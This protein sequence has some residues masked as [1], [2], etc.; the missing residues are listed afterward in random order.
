M[1]KKAM[2]TIPAMLSWTGIFIRKSS[3]LSIQ[4]TEIHF[5]WGMRTKRCRY[6][7]SWLTPFW[8]ILLHGYCHLS[9]RLERCSADW[10]LTLVSHW[11]RVITWPGYWPLIGALQCWLAS[12]MGT[13][14][15]DHYSGLNYPSLHSG[16]PGW[17]TVLA[18]LRRS[19]LGRFRLV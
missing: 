3:K 1:A 7:V 4:V 12:D 9:I 11:S 16:S 8:S 18:L 17:Q 10:H 19:C 13:A 2:A 15:S 5:I 14:C 6:Q